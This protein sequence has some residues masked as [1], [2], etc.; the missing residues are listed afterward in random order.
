[1]KK[2][3]YGILVLIFAFATAKA[4]QVQP[5][6]SAEPKNAASF[7]VAPTL[8]AVSLQSSPAVPATFSAVPG[9]AATRVEGM[10][11]DGNMVYLSQ[12][13]MSQVV[14]VY[15]CPCMMQNPYSVLGGV[16]ARTMPTVSAVEP[17]EPRVFPED[18][19][20][21]QKSKSKP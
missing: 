20:K 6:I 14:Y 19:I 10:P 16:F 11:Q 2:Q 12:A 3:F 9:V 5:R 4:Q 1:M 18:T 7:L 21:V 13:P 8:P 15:M 17:L